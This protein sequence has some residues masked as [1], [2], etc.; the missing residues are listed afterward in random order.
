MS[1]MKLCQFLQVVSLIYL[2]VIQCQAYMS[3]ITC[4]LRVLL[5]R[6]TRLV[7]WCFWKTRFTWPVIS[8]IS[9]TRWSSYSII[10]QYTTRPSCGIPDVFE[11]RW[12]GKRI[13]IV[14]P[15]EWISIP[16]LSS[17]LSFVCITNYTMILRILYKYISSTIQKRAITALTL[18]PNMQRRTPHR[19][20]S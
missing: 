13:K 5:R 4:F 19:R 20:H 6:N 9:I 15:V 12:K 11:S 14:E 16:S 8:S 18:V 3:F 7:S 17:H 2:F 10:I 1:A